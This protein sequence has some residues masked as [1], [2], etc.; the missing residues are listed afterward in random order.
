MKWNL[1]WM[2]T[3]LKPL[4]CTSLLQVPSAC[5]L[6]CFNQSSIS[7]VTGKACMLITVCLQWLF[8]RSL[9][10]A[11]F[12]AT[13]GAIFVGLFLCFI[14]F[15]LLRCATVVREH[16]VKGVK[17]NVYFLTS[18]EQRKQGEEFYLNNGF[19]VLLCARFYHTAW[20]V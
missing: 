14:L 16:L 20:L 11:S 6:D 18:Q 5:M 10:I 1:C 17:G 12:S 3:P 7:Q 15:S 13:G 2:A 8:G 9:A 4:A 19:C